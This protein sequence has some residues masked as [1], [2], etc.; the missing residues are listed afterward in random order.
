MGQY[1]ILNFLSGPVQLDLDIAHG[2]LGDGRNLPDLI[3]FTVK[4]MDE[5][6]FVFVQDDQCFFESAESLIAIYTGFLYFQQLGY[7]VQGVEVIRPQVD[8]VLRVDASP[9]RCG[10][11]AN[12]RQT[13]GFGGNQ[14]RRWQTQCPA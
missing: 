11:A 13:E 9:R 2:I 10:T 7:L 5:G 3:S 6:A 4:Q 8:P 14:D 12:G 1:V